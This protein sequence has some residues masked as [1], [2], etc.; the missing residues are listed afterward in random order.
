MSPQSTR[1]IV[2]VGGTGAQGQGV[3]KALLS[4]LYGDAWRIRALTRSPDSPK[5]Q[6]LLLNLQTSD[7]RL[8]LF[9]GHPYDATGLRH[10]FA[11]VYG[12]FAMTSE[13]Y[14]GK[15]L[16]NEEDLKHEIQAGK[17]MVLAAKECGVKHFVFSSLPDVAEVSGG[18][19]PGVHHMNNKAIIEEFARKELNGFTSLMPVSRNIVVYKWTDP[20]DDMGAF[21]AKIFA[22]GV[23]KTNGKTFLAMSAQLSADDMAKTFTRVTGRPAVHSPISFEEFARVAAPLV[24]PAFKED[25]KQMMEW[26]AVM[27]WDRICYGSMDPEDDVSKEILELKAS[28]FETWLKRSGWTGPTKLYEE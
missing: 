4:G 24:G 1:T 12:V 20:T 7:G 14:H 18:Q 22:V 11:G 27:P 15:T 26:A 5:A 9:P 10:A 3:I 21:A 23:E 16:V 28:S 13:I 17:N 8:S 6:S 2:V 25:A 19:F